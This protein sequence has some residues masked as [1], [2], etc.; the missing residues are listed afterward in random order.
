MNLS[1]LYI[2]RPIT[3]TLVT[4][5]ILIFGWMSYQTLPISYL[6]NV[7]YPTIQVTAS[8]P[9]ASPETMSAAIARPLEKQFSSIAG[10]DSLTS[11]STLGKTQLTLQFN[12]SRKIDD[13]AQDVEAA[14]SASSG[15]IPNDLPNPPYL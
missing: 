11:T 3:T 5:G 2:R 12:L 13:A 6:P 9:G 10:L 8:R 1:E 15:Q 7:D 4:I 14:I